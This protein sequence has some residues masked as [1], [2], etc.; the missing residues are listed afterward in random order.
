MSQSVSQSVS[1][2]V[3]QRVSQSV[4]QSLSQSV[5]SETS[6]RCIVLVGELRVFLGG[7]PELS[8]VFGVLFDKF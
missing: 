2:N 1:Q 6:D 5:S 3:S 8:C 7:G 4:R